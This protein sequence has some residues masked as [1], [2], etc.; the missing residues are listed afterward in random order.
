M[1]L[2]PFQKGKISEIFCFVLFCFVLFCFVLLF[3]R[4]RVSLYSPGCPGTH[5]VNQAGLK[6]RNPPASASQVLGSK[7][8]ATTAQQSQRFYKTVSWRLPWLSIVHWPSIC[9]STSK[10][11]SRNM[12]YLLLENKKLQNL[13]DDSAVKSTFCSSRGPGTW[14]PEPMPGSLQALVT[15]AL[16]NAFLWPLEV[17]R[18]NPPHLP[19]ETHKNISFPSFT[20]ISI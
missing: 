9:S 2:S 15:L 17:P 14:F 13:R 6:L 4:D 10:L 5:F 7:V 3:F 8:C 18:H 11:L 16:G 12:L 19:I 1:S 20:E